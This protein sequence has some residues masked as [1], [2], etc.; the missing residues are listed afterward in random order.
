VVLMSLGQ[1]RRRG[2]PN[3][4]KDVGHWLEA[5]KNVGVWHACPAFSFVSFVPFV[6]FSVVRPSTGT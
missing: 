6:S 3:S 1:R 2:N 4:N 5:N